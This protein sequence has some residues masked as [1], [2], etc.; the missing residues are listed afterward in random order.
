MKISIILA[1]PDQNSFNHAVART[2]VEQLG[3][4]GHT[5]FFHDLYAERFDPLLTGD[6]IYSRR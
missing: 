3:N 5:I 2:V 6:E 1:H 4:N